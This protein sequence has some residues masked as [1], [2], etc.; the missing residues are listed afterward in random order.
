MAEVPR[1]FPTHRPPRPHTTPPKTTSSPSKRPQMDTRTS[2]FSTFF[3]RVADLTVNARNNKYE[4]PANTLRSLVLQQ[5]DLE[6]QTRELEKRY[7]EA[8]EESQLTY[9]A[10]LAAG[11]GHSRQAAMVFNEAWRAKE[12]LRRQIVRHEALLEGVRVDIAV[13]RER[14]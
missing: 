3:E 1:I 8:I 13:L 12:G 6:T 5:K 4:D 9:R 14:R 2:S 11:R 10:Y 7:A